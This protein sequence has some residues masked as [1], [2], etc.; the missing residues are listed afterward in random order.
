[1]RASSS[2]GSVTKRSAGSTLET[3][4]A[5]ATPPAQPPRRVSA[6]L[7]LSA[8]IPRLLAHT[9]DQRQGRSNKSN[10]RLVPIGSAHAHSL[11]IVSFQRPCFRLR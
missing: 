10:R 5:T 3:S 4:H 6:A 8:P 11:G 2:L 1:M 9:A 7:E